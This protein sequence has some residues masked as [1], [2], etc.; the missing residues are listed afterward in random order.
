[1]FVLQLSPFFQC[2]SPRLPGLTKTT[3][4]PSA[5]VTACSLYAVCQNSQTSSPQR[6]TR[7]VH[8]LCGINEC[9]TTPEHKNYIRRKEV[10]YLT[11]H[12]THLVTVA[13]KIRDSSV[14]SKVGCTL[15]FCIET[16]K[17]KKNGI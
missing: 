10:F 11:M 14:V 4:L 9:L 1:M 2:Q 7:S 3:D 5:T 12:S 15:T 16:N 8:L 6:H 17:V 13:F